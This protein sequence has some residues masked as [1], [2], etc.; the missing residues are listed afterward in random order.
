METRLEELQKKFVN[1]RN[2]VFI[3][4]NS[5]TEQFHDSEVEDWD[6]GINDKN[7]PRRH[8]F[9]PETW[10]P[11]ELDCREWAKV[12]LS[13]KAKFAALTAKHHEGFCLWPT[14]TTEH[15]I[16]NGQYQHDVVKEYLEAFREAGIVAGL[17]FSMLDLQHDI[18]DRKCTAEDKAFIKA[19][20]GELL[21]NYG[22]IP[23]LI[24]DGW[25]APW[26]G[27]KFED[28]SFQEIDEYVKGIQPD[29]LVMN[30]GCVDS[31]KDTDIPFFENA[32]GQSAD[33]KF[34]GPGAA[35]NIFASTWFWRDEHTNS[36][37]KSAEWAAERVEEYNKKNIS[38]LMN[39]SP[40]NRGT[41]DANLKERFAEFGKLYHEIP[42]VE[43]LPEGWMRR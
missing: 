10:N 16:R 43:E 30:I 41:V 6:Y 31:L 34:E 3:H 17:Y 19:Q 24:I 7:D 9:H 25:N 28:L 35:A 4:F 14:Q 38:F 21:H 42:P 8:E 22:E 11:C 27:P 40:N 13:A 12:A 15:C 29:C 33:D 36:T 37:L 2:G 1:L 20:L 39:I 26:G 23:F 18:T 32:F 5:A